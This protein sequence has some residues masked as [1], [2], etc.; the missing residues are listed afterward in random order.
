MNFKFY[1]YGYFRPDKKEFFY[2]GKGCRGRAYIH[3]NNSHNSAVTRTIAKLKRNGFEPEVRLLFEGGDLDCKRVEIELIAFHGRKDLGKGYL[4][5]MTDGGDGTVGRVVAEAQRLAFSKQSKAAWSDATI[6]LKIIAGLKESWQRPLTRAHRM[7]G[8]RKAGE[9]H[10]I[11]II[12]N[13][14]ERERLRQQM[15]NAWLNP[16]F[17]Q[18]ITEAVKRQTDNLQ[19]RQ[20][21][22]QKI[23]TKWKTDPSYRQR[24]SRGMKLKFAE[25][26]FLQKFREICAYPDRRR[27][28]AT[29]ASLRKQTEQTKDKLSFMQKKLNEDQVAFARGMHQQGKS[30]GAVSK[31]FGV[32]YAVMYRAIYGQRRAYAQ[33]AAEKETIQK[34]ILRN[35]ERAARG[36]RLLS[37]EDLAKVKKLRAHG[38]AFA[39]IGRTFGVSKT[40]IM[41]IFKGKIYRETKAI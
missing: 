7:A 25:P 27:K 32:S 11:R 26:Q 34:A 29:A 23:K 16:E 12:N 13:P 22:S 35:R 31:E 2:I 39:K 37:G 19:F 28:I 9:K 41:N 10:R 24:V 36:R 30:I 21:M 14:E 17:R 6:R 40:T 38:F 15:R 8:A 33:G 18:R 5:N 20:L 1:V 3:F 4:L